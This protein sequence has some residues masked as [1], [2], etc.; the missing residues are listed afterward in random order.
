MVIRGF[1]N[2]GWS[3]VFLPVLYQTSNN[4]RILALRADAE[5]NAQKKPSEQNQEKLEDAARVI[6]RG[7]TI[8]IADRAPIEDSRK[9]GTYYMTNLLFRMYFKVSQLSKLNLGESVFVNLLE[10]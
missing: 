3:N 8:C 5:V 10:K 1:Q 4:L 6:N 7:F 9:W 2:A